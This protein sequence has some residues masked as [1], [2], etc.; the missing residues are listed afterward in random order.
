V[1]IVVLTA[2]VAAWLR[3]PAFDALWTTPYGLALVRKVI[4]VLVVLGFGVYHWRRVVIPDWTKNTLSRFKR[5]AVLELLF[6]GV[7]VAL[8]AY[9]LTQPLP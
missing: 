2:V 3:L 6:G 4:F 8:T 7:V 5:S 9:L 1:I